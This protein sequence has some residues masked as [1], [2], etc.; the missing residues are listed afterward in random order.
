TRR[1][2][3]RACAMVV[4]GGLSVI[5]PHP[6]RV[7]HAPNPLEFQRKMRPQRQRSATLWMKPDARAGAKLGQCEPGARYSACRWRFGGPPATIAASSSPGLPLDKRLRPARRLAP[8]PVARDRDRAR[9]MGSVRTTTIFQTWMAREEPNRKKPLAAPP[10]R[11]PR[12]RATSVVSAVA[13]VALGT[14]ITTRQRGWAVV[15]QARPAG[16]PAR[17]AATKEDR[18]PN[19]RQAMQ[20]AASVRSGTTSAWSAPGR[21]LS[22]KCLPLTARIRVGGMTDAAIATARPCLA[23]LRADAAST[24]PESVAWPVTMSGTVHRV[25]RAISRPACASTATATTIAARGYATQADASSAA[26]LKI[27]T[28]APATTIASAVDAS[29]ASRIWNVTNCCA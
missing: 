5:V 20:A 18:A 23:P 11:A 4:I 2:A 25:K 17:A 6:E 7:R 12:Q 16:S 22:A 3:R 8:P 1:P 19:A 28:R 29:S 15:H 24:S 27:V 9:A 10:A 14:S 13:T 21:R 26:P